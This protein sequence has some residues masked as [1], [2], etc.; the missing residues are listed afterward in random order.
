MTR[1][2]RRRQQQQRQRRRQR[3]RRLDCAD[4]ADDDEDDNYI[5]II[6]P[7]R[8][9]SIINNTPSLSIPIVVIGCLDYLVW[10]RLLKK[11]Q[12]SQT[13]DA[14]DTGHKESMISLSEAVSFMDG[15]NGTKL[16]I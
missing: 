13:R 14:V 3:R 1:R 4:D 10:M 12:W 8:R 16:K 5:I 9:N 11:T 6:I 15:E 2:R 7:P